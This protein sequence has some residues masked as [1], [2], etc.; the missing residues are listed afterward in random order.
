[1]TLYIGTLG[2]GVHKN[3]GF[4]ENS[5]KCFT[6]YSDVMITLTSVVSIPYLSNV[7]SSTGLPSRYHEDKFTVFEMCISPH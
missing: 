7:G 3:A 5:K 6:E 4:C 1:M 2:L